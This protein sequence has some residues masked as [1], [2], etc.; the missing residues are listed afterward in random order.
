MRTLRLEAIFV[1]QAAWLA[2]GIAT[3]AGVRNGPEYRLAGF[4]DGKR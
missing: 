3:D 2:I 4:R 1:P